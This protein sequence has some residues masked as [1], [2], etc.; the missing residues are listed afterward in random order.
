MTDFSHLDAIQA[1]L[2]REEMRLMDAVTPAEKAF[3]AQQVASAKKEED[4]EYAFLGIERP[5]PM[6][7]DE[8]MAELD[9]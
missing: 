9:A 6:T 3:R 4:A 8:I 2:F 5:A 1:R 7:M